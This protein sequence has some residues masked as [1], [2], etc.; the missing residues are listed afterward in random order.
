MVQT[1]DLAELDGVDG[2]ANVT[3]SGE[4][5]SMVMVVYLVAVA[6][7]SLLNSAVTAY[8]ENG[9]EFLPRLALLWQVQVA[10]DV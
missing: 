2:E 6:D 7:A 5:C 10:R 8:V 4:P 9:G 3:V 1:L